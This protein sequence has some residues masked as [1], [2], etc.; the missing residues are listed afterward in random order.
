MIIA[1]LIGKHSGRLTVLNNEEMENEQIEK[2]EHF[3]ANEVIKGYCPFSGLKIIACKKR[4]C[5]CFEFEDV[6]GV[7]QK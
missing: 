4:L 7:S 2:W 5:D 1:S 6:Y 3:K